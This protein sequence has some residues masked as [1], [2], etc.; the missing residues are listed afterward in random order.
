MENTEKKNLF[1]N[2]AVCD[3]RGIRESVLESYASVSINAAVLVADAASQELMDR[4]GVK[5]NSA[6]VQLIEDGNVLCEAFN[7]MLELGP[8]AA[9]AQPTCLLVNGKLTILPGA[10]DT[11]AGYLGITVNGKVLC[12]ESLSGRIRGLTVNGRLTAYPDDCIL[13]KNTLVLDRTFPLRCRQNARY[14]AGSR[15]V[16]LAPD[17]GVEKLVEKGVSFVTPR[18]IAAESLVEAAMPLFD[19]K[20]DI[21]IV[22]DGC[23]FVDDDAEL[24]DSLLRR[25]GDKLYINGDLTVGKDAA[26]ALSQVKYLKVDGDVAVV[27]SLEEAF[28]AVKAEYDGLTAISGDVLRDY[29]SVTVDRA[30]LERAADGLTITGCANVRF[31]PDI[32]P[33]LLQER[34]WSITDCAH[35]DCTEEQAGVIFL[36]AKDVASINSASQAEAAEEDE[37]RVTISAISYKF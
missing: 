3:V 22:P 10:E 4:Y 13:M 16:A 11:L 36:V 31:A 17:I 7:G 6:S 23:A 33:A 30:M 24:T 15:V 37:D 35:V 25:Y 29:G 27:K 18:V 9:P 28:H 26:Q 20:A 2:A 21:T 19:E 8:N 5:R 34:L 1:I 32:P 14:F 12:P